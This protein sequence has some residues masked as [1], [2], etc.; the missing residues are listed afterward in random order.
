MGHE[1]APS[2]HTPNVETPFTSLLHL[3]RSKLPLMS[4]IPNKK[5]ILAKTAHVTPEFFH[6][7]PL[8]QENTL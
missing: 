8:L 1:R 6:T 3:A 2:S 7:M 5:Q 4:N